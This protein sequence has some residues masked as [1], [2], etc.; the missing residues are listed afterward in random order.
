[1]VELTVGLIITCFAPV[2]KLARVV[3]NERFPTLLGSNSQ[4]APGERPIS[5]KPH[6]KH[7]PGGLSELDSMKTFGS[8]VDTEVKMSSSLETVRRY[9]TLTI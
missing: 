3:I 7:F 9:D 2:S 4:T 1:M 6:R 8:T 5:M